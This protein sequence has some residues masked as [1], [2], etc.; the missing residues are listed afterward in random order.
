MKWEYIYKRK[1][2][3]QRREWIGKFTKVRKLAKRE[4]I[5]KFRKVRKLAKVENG[6]CSAPLNPFSASCM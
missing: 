5:G 3:S 6:F 1:E 4:W 2:T